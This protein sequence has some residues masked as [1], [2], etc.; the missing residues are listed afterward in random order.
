[1]ELWGEVINLLITTGSIFIKRNLNV[2]F[3][4]IIITI[5][6][7]ILPKNNNKKSNFFN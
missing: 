6:K 1:M 4:P 7:Y 5:S 3:I 2:I